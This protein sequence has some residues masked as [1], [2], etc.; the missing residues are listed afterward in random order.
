MSDI[1]ENKYILVVDDDP[2]MQ[3]V[4]Q[5]MIEKA[6][7]KPVIAENGEKALQF[8]ELGGANIGVVLL[9]RHMPDMDGF[10]VVEKIQSLDT[11]YGIPVI[12]QSGSKTP[13]DIRDAIDAGV[14]YYLTKPFK[15]EALQSALNFAIEKSALSVVLQERLA[16]GY[17]PFNLIKSASFEF[18]DISDAKRMA[19][20]LS[21]LFPDPTHVFPGV[22]GLLS[23][24]VEHGNLGLGYDAKSELIDAAKYEQGIEDLAQ[25]SDKIVEV[26]FIH[27]DGR[28]SIR[29]TD[30]GSG[31]DWKALTEFTEARDSYTH[32]YGILKALNSFD[33]VKY[34]TA[35]NQVMAS[36]LEK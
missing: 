17:T 31:F 20:L 19:V 3:M 21:C 36:V 35:G 8:V 18:K 12:M 5:G 7:F 24:A 32:G 29:I 11:N 34:N 14:F 9:D 28:F 26:Q 27:K 33:E 30:Q 10:E 15:I 23:N 13:K 16:E 2:T 4:L 25:K 22:L 6:G 1:S